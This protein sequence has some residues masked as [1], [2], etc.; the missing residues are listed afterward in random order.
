MAAA[1]VLAEVWSNTGIDG[2]AVHATALPIGNE[3]KPLPPDPRW[4]ADH[5]IQSRYSLQMVKCTNEDCCQP[6]VT[7]WL[8]VFPVRFLPNPAVYEYS[9]VGQSAVEPKKFTENPKLYA[10][11]PLQQRLLL[12]LQPGEASKYERTS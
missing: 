7:N 6:F 8:S 11:S 1:E 4:V 10:F 9:N 3:Y 5:V 12:K 2:H